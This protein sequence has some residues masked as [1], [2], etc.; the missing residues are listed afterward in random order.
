MSAH[1]Q[2]HLF[3][4][5][6]IRQ[7]ERHPLLR[8]LHVCRAGYFPDFD[9]YETSRPAGFPS[10]HIM[11]YCLEGQGWFEA[12]G[13]RWTI[14]PGQLLFVL[15]DTPHGYG[16]IADKPWTVQWVHFSGSEAASYLQWLRV[17][18]GAPILP[19]RDQ[20]QMS[21][22]FNEL[23]AFCQMGYS[24]SF[25]LNGAA[26]L[27]QILSLMVLQ[28][29]GTTTNRGRIDV[30]VVIQFMLAHL[31]EKMTVGRLARRAN[32]SVSHF[33]HQFQRQMG[34]AP[35]DYFIRLR[36][37]R[38]CELLSTSGLLIQEI[39]QEVGYHDPYYFSRIFKK[40]MG[41]SPR[42]YRQARRYVV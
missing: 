15:Q 4:D 17:T 22:L 25:L 9:D 40:T 37:Q 24:H 1:E 33:A 21:R 29:S 41:E 38:A 11:I 2:F 20:L 14:S 19:V 8:G 30:E 12:A 23:L 26:L 7:Q 3:P 39:G 32:L 5:E 18:P 28:Q 34:Y 27:R 13:Q 42:A 10:S 16:A 31:A 36:M 35:L 6:I